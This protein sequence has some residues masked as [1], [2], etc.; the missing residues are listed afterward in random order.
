MV[1]CF[2]IT[3]IKYYVILLVLSYIAHLVE[4][5]EQYNLVGLLSLSVVSTMEDTRSTLSFIDW[6]Q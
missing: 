3:I 1:V 5:G 2:N 6:L 4:Q